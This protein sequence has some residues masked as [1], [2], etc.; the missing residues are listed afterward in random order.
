MTNEEAF[1]A[2]L[3]HHGELSQ[4]VAR[5]VAA[6][7][8]AAN[9]TSFEVPRAALVDY[10]A[11]DV[12]THA[13]AEED[14]IYRVASAR[15]ELT[16]T[17]QQMTF[18]HREIATKIERLATAGDAVAAAQLGESISRVF[19]EHVNKENLIVLPAL[20]ADPAVDLAAILH[21]MHRR[22]A[23]DHRADAVE[24]DASTPDHEALV[25]TQLL[26]A[27]DHLARA[28]Q[29]DLACSIAARAWATLRA[30]RPDLAHRVNTAMHRLVRLISAEP[31]SLRAKDLATES[32]ASPVLDVRTM[33]PAQRHETIFASY[34]SLDEGAAFLL[35]NDHDPKPLRYQFE[36]EHP[37]E[38]T[39]DYFETGPKVWRVR[40]GRVTHEELTDLGRS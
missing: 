14:T 16:A 36:A 32:G 24:V 1:R 35:V 23:P 8:A 12:L 3:A 40:I 26:E 27:A 37:G 21:G 25:V 39:W 11:N 31:V 33:A 13:S 15:S 18:E 30:P 5:R 22:T 9:S 10:L 4:E 19:D 7:S 2:M 20:M 17:V 29:G 28:G 34:H 6:L 38:F